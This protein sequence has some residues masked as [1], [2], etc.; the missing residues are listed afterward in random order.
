MPDRWVH[1]RLRSGQAIVLIDGLDE[2]AASRRNEVRDWL[3]DLVGTFPDARYVVSSRPYAAEEGWLAEQDFADV[4]LQDMAG[5]D[6]DQFVE[7]WHKAVREGLQREE[8]KTELDDLQEHLREVVKHNRTIRRLATSPLLCALLCALHRDRVK[9]LPSDRIELY[10]ACCDM[11]LRRD[12]ER[13]VSLDDYPDIGDRQKRALLQ[14]FAYWLI[15]NGWSEVG[16]DK[17]DGRFAV[18]LKSLGQIP[19]GTEGSDVRRLFIERS[20]ILRH[21][22]AEMVDFPHRTFQEYLAAIAAMEEGDSGVLVKHAHDDQWHEMIILA[23][24]LARSS[25]ANAIIQ[26]L[27]ARG[28]NQKSLRHQLHLLAVACLETVL[29]PAEDICRSVEKRL[30]KIVPPK[31]MTEA[32]ALASAGDL[33]VPHLAYRRGMKA[34]QAAASLRTLALIGTE[35]AHRALEAYGDDTRNSVQDAILRTFRCVADPQELLKA[36]SR[37]ATLL[38]LPNTTISDLSPLAGLTGLRSLNLGS[39]PVIDLSPLAGLTG[40]RA[41]DLWGATVTDLSL[42]AGLTGLQSLDLRRTRV[43]DLSPVKGIRGLKIKGPRFVSRLG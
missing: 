27:I 10:R 40:L 5:A 37:R 24:G 14:D 39:T 41:L 12:L 13:R 11:F 22:T 34:A 35:A 23:A 15:K 3:K 2:L 43:T 30:I 42:L 29:E 33:V 26:Q 20:G 6:I 19:S 38:N 8:E 16:T 1:D 7:H 28:D 25:E 32:K 4:E 17:A 31:T 9:Q 18:K 21:P 36:L